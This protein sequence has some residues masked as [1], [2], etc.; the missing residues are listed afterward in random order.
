M[1]SHVIGTKSLSLFL[2]YLLLSFLFSSFR[3]QT[4]D[5]TV[6]VLRVYTQNPSPSSD[7]KRVGTAPS[8]GQVRITNLSERARLIRS[9]LTGNFPDQSCVGVAC[10]PTF[11]FEA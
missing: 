4:K 7:P 8:D 6:H 2:V 3:Q 10:G 9:R 5:H 11:E 1:E